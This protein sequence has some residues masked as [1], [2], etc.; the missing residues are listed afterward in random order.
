[1][2]NKFDKLGKIMECDHQTNWHELELQSGSY[3][4]W[5]SNIGTSQQ[6]GI[7]IYMHVYI[8]IYIHVYKHGI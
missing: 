3:Y 6:L 1:M 7:Y 2:V 4:C 5:N 8:Y